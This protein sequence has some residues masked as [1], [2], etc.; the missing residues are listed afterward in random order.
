MAAVDI[1]APERGRPTGNHHSYG[2]RPFFLPGD[3]VHCENSSVIFLL[4]VLLAVI[5]LVLYAP[6][7]SFSKTP[8]ISL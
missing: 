2:A 3:G 5:F 6:L 1:S 4:L 7:L 8:G